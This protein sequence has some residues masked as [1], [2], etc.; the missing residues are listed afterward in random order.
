M[1]MR[2]F[3]RI[4]LGLGIGLALASLLVT[5]SPLE[6]QGRG[7]GSPP[8]GLPPGPPTFHDRAGF[9][10][11]PPFVPPGLGGDNPGRGG[12]PPGLRAALIE[13][14]FGAESEAEALTIAFSALLESPDA[15]RATVV[16]YNEFVD[17]SSDGFVHQPPMEFQTLRSVLTPLVAGVMEGSELAYSAFLAAS[18]AWLTQSPVVAQGAPSAPVGPVVLADRD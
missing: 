12:G 3:L 17:A 5:S 8:F 9:P 18:S 11:G 13:D 10:P 4:D 2:R 1:T 6:A 15:L 7:R 14:N 16:A